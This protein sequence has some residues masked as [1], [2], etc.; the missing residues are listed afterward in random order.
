[1]AALIDSLLVMV[2]LLNFALLGSSRLR[3]VITVSAFQ[4]VVLGI[5]SALVHKTFTITPVV[6]ALISIFIKGVLI[7]SSL[8]KAMRE[9]KIRREIE[10]LIGYLPSLLLGALATGVAI[11]FAHTL[12]LSMEGSAL[13]VPSSIATVLTGFLI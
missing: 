3:A 8:V 5:L 9:A 4:G 6:V 1:M 12:P 2:L 13:I 10:P 7:P 11:L